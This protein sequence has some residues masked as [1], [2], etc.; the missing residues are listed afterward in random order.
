MIMSEKISVNECKV[1]RPRAL[2]SSV[3]YL[4]KYMIVF[5]G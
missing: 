5:G 3:S 1:P 2:H 4:N